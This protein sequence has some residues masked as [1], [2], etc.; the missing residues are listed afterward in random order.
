VSTDDAPNGIASQWQVAVGSI[1]TNELLTF[2]V[3]TS[4]IVGK[5][6]REPYNPVFDDRA[7]PFLEG[8]WTLDSTD[9]ART[10]V[11][12]G[13]AHRFFLEADDSGVLAWTI[14]TESGERAVVQ[15]GK[16]TLETPPPSKPKRAR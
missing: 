12:P 8:T 11:D 16:A 9:A 13:V 3:A 1:N 14:V 2:K 5:P 6:V 4:G 10:L 7:P 15:A